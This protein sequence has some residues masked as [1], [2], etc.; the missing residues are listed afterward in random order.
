MRIAL[1]GP[2]GS[3]KGTQAAII[4]QTFELVHLASGDILRAEKASG[5]PL[6]LKVREFIDNGMLVPD[7]VMLDIIRDKIVKLPRGFVLDG[8]PRT[9]P[10]AKALNTMLFEMDRPL[11]LMLNFVVNPPHSRPPLRR[12]P[13]LPRLSQR[14]PHRRQAAPAARRLRQRRR[15]PHHP[16]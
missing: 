12:P 5:S 15:R 4:C 1:L 8:F 3:G 14:L 9:L 2:P 6:G 13:R 11:N 10:Q 16:R 7:D